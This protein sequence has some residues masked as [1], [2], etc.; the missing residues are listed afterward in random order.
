MYQLCL[1]TS[2]SIR[3]LSISIRLPPQ[4]PPPSYSYDTMPRG[5]SPLSLSSYTYPP[6][7][8]L[9]S[10]F[11]FS[12]FFSLFCACWNTT[13]IVFPE[14]V[15]K[16]VYQYHLTTSIPVFCPSFPRAHFFPSLK[17]SINLFLFSLPPPS[18]TCPRYI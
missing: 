15:P 7:S 11:F 2:N 8:T 1:F 6:L 16:L 3:A 12:L 4:F 14:Y 17:P 13:G 18:S 10:I 5:I 9:Q